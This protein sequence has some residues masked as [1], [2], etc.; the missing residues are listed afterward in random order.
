ML[1]SVRLGSINIF[2][3]KI[4]YVYVPIDT[5]S[6]VRLSSR[7]L[8]RALFF[9]SYAFLSLCTK[10]NI[11]ERNQSDPYVRNNLFASTLAGELGLGSSRTFLTPMRMLA[12]EREARQF[13]WIVSPLRE[14]FPSSS[15]LGVEK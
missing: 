13:M 6:R 7:M 5:F 11:I 8:F 14:D 4:L 12:M 9:S 2:S 1:S 3:D 15:V 10:K